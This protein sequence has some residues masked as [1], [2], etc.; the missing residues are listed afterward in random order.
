MRIV[1]L[2]IMGIERPSGRRYFQ[3][4]RGL[5]AQG[6][7]VRLLALHPDLAA[8]ERRR[9]VRDGVEVWYVGQMHA[10][11]AGSVPGRFG[12]LALLRVLAGSTLGMIWGVICSPADLYHLGKPQPVNGLA[13]LVAVRLLRRMPFYVD[14]DDDEVRG[15]RLTAPWQRA[16]FGFWQ[17]LLP[18]LAAGVTVNTPHL[19]AE[20]SRLGAHNVVYVPN[21]VD[22]A[23]LSPP[24]GPRLDAL[25]AALGLAGRR[26]VAYAGTLALQNHPVDLLLEAFAA[27]ARELPDVDLLIVGGGEDLDALRALAGRL[28]LEDRVY[29]TGHLHHAAVAAFL[30]LAE[31][32]VDPVRDDPVARARSPLKLF[33]SM[34]LGVPVVTGDVGDRS[35]LLAGGVAGALV[36]PDDPNALAS[37]IVGLLRN[38]PRRLAMAAAARAQARRYAWPDLARAWAAVYTPRARPESGRAEQL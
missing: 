17:R 3:I 35:A 36:A 13:A 10:R 27:V 20:V 34:A 31:L 32:S 12:P 25:R 7:S 30:A 4:A 16:V 38:E 37:A 19:A 8:C 11:K 33:E 28:G 26:L 2:I 6:H 1:F 5:A 21:G 14:C 29:F 22:L 15:N 18:R 9:F 23:R 24:P